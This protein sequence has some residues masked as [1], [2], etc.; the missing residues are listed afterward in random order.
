MFDEL[1][2]LTMELTNISKFHTKTLTQLCGGVRVLNLLFYRPINYIDRRKNLLSA[3]AGEFTTLI[4]EVCEHRFS[5]LKGKPYKIIVKSDDKYVFL[6]FFYYSI[7]YLSQ[8]FPVGSKVIVSGKLE[9]FGKQL[10]ITHPDYLLRDLN[11]FQEIACIESIY[12]LSR[13]ITNRTIKT[14]INSCLCR[15]T[16]LSEWIDEKLITQNNWFGWRKSIIG[17]HNPNSLSEIERCRKRLAYDELLAYQITL[18]LTRQCSLKERN[19]KFIIS[20]KYAKQILNELPFQLTEDQKKAIKE[21]SEKQKSKYRMINLLQGDVGSG[22]TVVALFAMLNAVENGLQVALMAPTTILACQHYE[23]IEGILSVTNIKV[24]LLTGKTSCKE[25]RFIANKLLNGELHIV[26]GTHA[27]FQDK[28]VFKNL[29]LVVIDEQQRFGVMQRSSL[30]QKGNTVDVLFVT[31][32]PIPRTLQQTIYGDIECSILREKPKFRPSVKTVAIN[33]QKRDNIIMRLSDAL[34]RG[35]KAYWVCP[36]IEES[37]ESIAAV[38][39][40]FKELKKLLQGKVVIIHGK[41]TPD[42]KDQVMFSFKRGEFSLLVATT[43]I[44]VGIDIP[45]ATIMVIEN[46]EQFGLS[47]LHQLRGRVGR[48]NKPSFCILLYDKLSKSTKMKIKI[49]RKSNDGFEIAEQDMLLRGSGNILGTKQSGHIEFKFVDLYKDKELCD[50]AYK[51]EYR[52]SKFLLS[53]FEYE[54]LL[55]FI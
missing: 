31:G 25:R 48:G 55:E 35:E 40:R 45:D 52:E 22:K 33:M 12:R 9:E 51:S 1:T 47:Q 49:M 18:K 28:V 42:E 50:L 11:R 44:E 15:L 3:K 6:I 16:D 17:L 24:G 29:G 53:L 26:I 36:Y 19:R 30:M 10:Q 27:L 14:I 38:E 8:I 46:A 43:V 2:S 37:N 13:G 21:I 32:T 39:M 20:D 23:W 5:H 54:G 34:N 7:K 41:L 4:G